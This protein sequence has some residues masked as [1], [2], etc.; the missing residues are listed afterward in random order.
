LSWDPDGGTSYSAVGQVKD[1]V[2]P[3]FT[4]TD[5]EIVD[6]DLT[7]YVKE[8]IPG[9]VDPGTLTFTLGWDPGDADHAEGIGTGII[10]SFEHDGCELPAWKLV[11]DTCN[12]TATWTGDGYPNAFTLNAPVDGELTADV[13]VK[14][15]AKQTLV[16]S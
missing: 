10:G 1:I 9:L 13:T 3:T 8:Y 4:R 2:Y 5:I 7:S 6:H 11:L 14:L 16:V 12:G 15:S